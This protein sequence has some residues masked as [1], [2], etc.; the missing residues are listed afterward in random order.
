MIKVNENNAIRLMEMIIN[1]TGGS[2]GVRDYSL[3]DSAL[4]SCFQSFNGVDLYLTV[5]EKGTWLGYNLIKNHAFVDGNKRIGLLVMLTFFEINNIKLSFT[6]S[7]LTSTISG[8]ASGEMS[9]NRLL[10]FVIGHEI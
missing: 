6:D 9:Y 4:N 3:L 1:K 7:E 8:V 10:D 2:Y 5:E